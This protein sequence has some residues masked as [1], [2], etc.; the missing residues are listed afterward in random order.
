MKE[1]EAVLRCHHP[2]GFALL[3]L[4]SSFGDFEDAVYT[5]AAVDPAE[6]WVSHFL[7]LEAQVCLLSVWGRCFREVLVFSLMGVLEVE[8]PVEIQRGEVE[9]VA[10]A[11]VLETELGALLPAC[12]ERYSEYNKTKGLY[13]FQMTAM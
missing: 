3:F 13:H 12:R 1:E 2:S 7:T 10:E 11:G 4:A 6:T 8:V 5:I 9:G